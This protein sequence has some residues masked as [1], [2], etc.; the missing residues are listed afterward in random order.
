[1]NRDEFIESN[2]GLVHTCALRFKNKGIEYDDLYSTGCMGLVK[3]VDNF[4]SSRGFCFSTYAVPVILGEIRRLFRDGGAIKVSR[5]L[6]ELSLKINRTIKEFQ[7][8]NGYEP[9]VLQ[10]AEIMQLEPQQVSEAINAVAH[11]VSLTFDA[12]DGEKQIDIPIAPPE[13]KLTE[14]MALR[15]IIGELDDVDREIITLRFFKNKTQSET[16]NILKMSQVQVSRKEKKILEKMK[17][18]LE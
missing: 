6:K 2:L 3:A 17:K 15:Q 7:E 5:S 9:T 16:G 12:E 14:I 4:D 10:I 11:P 8:E 13:E 1:M 18:K